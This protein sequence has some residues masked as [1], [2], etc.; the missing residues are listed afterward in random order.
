MQCI[1]KHGHSGH[2]LAGLGEGGE[3]PLHMIKHYG[4]ACLKRRFA[5]VQVGQSG[6][7][8]RPLIGELAPSPH[9]FMFDVVSQSSL[10]FLLVR[11]RFLMEGS[12]VQ[13]RY[14]GL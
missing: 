10:L 8:S 7:N 5:L 3:L 11:C 13:S 6:L 4:L 1:Q 2:V 12:G 9:G 14:G